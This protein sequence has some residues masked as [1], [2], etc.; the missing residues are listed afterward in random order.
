MTT[1]DDVRAGAPGTTPF[2]RDLAATAL[3]LAVAAF[4]WFGWSG[5]AAPSWWPTFAVPGSVAAVTTAVLA[6]LQVR[7]ERRSGTVMV[8]PGASARYGRWVGAEV[9]AIVVGWVVLALLG[10]VD[11]VAAWV[12]GV[13]GAHFLP[14]G[15]LFRVRLLRVCGVVL[16]G[17]AV[18]AVVLDVLDVTA[19]STVAGGAG[20]VV[21]TGTAVFCLRAGR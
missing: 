10:A 2:P 20:G 19:A 21:L 1:S 18:V 14:L 12:L 11:L 8:E 6:G 5:A 4:A 13:V 3:V 15:D 16:V 7:R 17:V 9:V